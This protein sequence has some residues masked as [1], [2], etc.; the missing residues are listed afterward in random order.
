MIYR[1]KGPTIIMMICW[2]GMTGKLCSQSA[3][4]DHMGVGFGL[5]AGLGTHF[6][7]LG[8]CF[9][10][11]Y[12]DEQRQVQLNADIR[13]YGNV[14]N[15]GPP[16]FSPEVQA[17]LGAVFLYGKKN[18]VVNDLFLTCVSNQSHFSN[19]VGYA[20]QVY[21]NPI[22]TR[23]RT[24]T[25]SFRFGRWDLIS[26]N[27]IFAKPILDRFRTGAILLQYTADPQHQYG[28][29]CTLWTGE[30]HHH[31][32]IKNEHFPDGYMDSV[33]AT[34]SGYSHGLL[35][36]Q[37]KT[38]L[39][40]YDQPA[41][42]HPAQASIGIDAEQVRNAVQN[43]FIHDQYFLPRLWRSGHNC[44]MPM[45]DDQGQQFLYLPGQKRKKPR[46]YLNGF[47]NPLLFY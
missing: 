21:I 2:L 17:C 45:A 24:G 37:V 33:G 15:L 19:S 14:K 16:G 46:P 44:D 10:A 9:R 42:T 26:E 32:E 39:P 47:L 28:L 6:D 41:L 8:V 38:M 34:Y 27:D 3:V 13:F 1:I 12:L 43:K 36:L 35:S 25:V 4:S 22:G 40:F 20:Q 7:R 11:Y 18:P 31:A 30:M 5:V 29:N 23:Q